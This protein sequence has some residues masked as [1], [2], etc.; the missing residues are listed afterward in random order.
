ME[1]SAVITA[2]AAL[3]QTSR[4]DIYR[5]LVQ[6]GPS[7]LAAGAIG[8][9]LKLPAS[10]LSFHLNQLQ[11]AGLISNQRD[12]RSLIYATEYDRMNSLL[13][14][15]TENCCQG[16]TSACDTA[17]CNTAHGDTANGDTAS[18]DTASG[19][20]ANRNITNYESS[21]SDPMVAATTQ[22]HNNDNTTR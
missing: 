19:D 1:Q 5:L 16:D 13:S 22:G 3:A 15:L 8:D 20:S 12:G 4:L 17:T 6:A 11:Q 7:G 2:L 9:Q 21:S 18:S 14:Y 10:T